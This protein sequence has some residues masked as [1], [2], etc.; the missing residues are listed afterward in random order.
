MKEIL[1]VLSEDLTLKKA[2][3][4]R[5]L[6]KSME[7]E[8]IRKVFVPTMCAVGICVLMA[9]SVIV[10]VTYF[11]ESSNTMEDLPE[12]GLALLFF[13][14]GIAFGMMILKS[15]DTSM[16]NEIINPVIDGALEKVCEDETEN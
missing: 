1:K 2:L 3:R 10:L 14:M 7:T 8:W 13:M 6:K 4:I 16:I 5:E 12:L 15:N 11:G 9:F